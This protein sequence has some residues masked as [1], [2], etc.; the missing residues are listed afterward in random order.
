MLL[1]CLVS[2]E[3]VLIAKCLVRS[4]FSLQGNVPHVA[5]NVWPNDILEFVL[6]EE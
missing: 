4:S 3:F 2:K 5:R 1:S 6:I